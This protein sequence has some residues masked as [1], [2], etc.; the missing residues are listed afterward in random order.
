M[1]ERHRPKWAL[2]EEG[3]HKVRVSKNLVEAYGNK[4]PII[5]WKVR[6]VVTEGPS[7]YK[8]VLFNLFFPPS[9]LPQNYPDMYVI[10]NRQFF[11]A[12]GLAAPK[13]GP[14]HWTV[15]PPKSHV[16]GKHLWV[17]TTHRWTTLA[18]GRYKYE[19]GLCDRDNPFKSIN[20]M[21]KDIEKRDYVPQDVPL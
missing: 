10:R 16:K 11:G 8:R 7:I 13:T 6:L 3:W 17:H 20:S 5:Y 19:G 9:P 2:K 15:P 4:H 21:D 14:G 1:L 18:P 12:I